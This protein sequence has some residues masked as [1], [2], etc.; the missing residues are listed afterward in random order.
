[1]PSV[2]TA[3]S[4]HLG[5]HCRGLLPFIYLGPPMWLGSKARVQDCNMPTS[6]RQGE[7]GRPPWKECSG[8]FLL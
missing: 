3:S 7:T 5:P 6:T 1:M 2:T 8:S 4:N